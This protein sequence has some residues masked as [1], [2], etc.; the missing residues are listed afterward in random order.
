MNPVNREKCHVVIVDYGLGNLYSVTRAVNHIGASVNISNDAA[1]IK[2]ADRLILPGV[3]AFPDCMRNLKERDLLSSLYITFHKGKPFLGICL[4]LQLLLSES[5]EFGPT[6]GLNMIR[7][8]VKRFPD[9]LGELAH[10]PKGVYKV[11][12]MGWNQVWQ[13]G[14]NPLMLGVPDGSYFYFVH[15]YFVM[16]ME[17]GAVSGTTDYG[18]QFTSMVRK[19]NIHGV[20]FHP[21]KSQQ[22]G[23][24][25]LKNFGELK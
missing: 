17:F 18:I 20:Q 8:T 1:T 15:S 2:K 10:D 16:P 25:V 21:E 4:G 23:L 13:V 19:D 22:V 11:P 12:H 14:D 9:N 7:G 6:G 24:R 5:D 3:G